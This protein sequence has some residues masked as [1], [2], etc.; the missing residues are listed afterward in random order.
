M[1]AYG[2]WGVSFLPCRREA[3]PG[4]RWRVWFIE[5]HDLLV[6]NRNVW[7]FSGQRY[8]PILWGSSLDDVL[9]DG[10]DI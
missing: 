2:V 7:I 4:R 3:V 5:D 9:G 6:V 8:E 1:G 10:V